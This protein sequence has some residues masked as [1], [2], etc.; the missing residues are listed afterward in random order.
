MD[1][2][3]REIWESEGERWRET[4]DRRKERGKERRTQRQRCGLAC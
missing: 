2:E 4:E 3:E 1:T